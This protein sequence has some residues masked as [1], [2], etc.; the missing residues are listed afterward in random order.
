MTVLGAVVLIRY[1]EQYVDYSHRMLWMWPLVAIGI[2][3]GGAFALD[4]LWPDAVSWIRLVARGALVTGL[5]A[6]TLLLF[7]REPLLKGWSM[8]WGLV[9]SQ[10]RKR[11]TSD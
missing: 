7:E 11:A 2:A 6:G 5:Y 3:A 8:V 1:V 4:G 10:L 9:R